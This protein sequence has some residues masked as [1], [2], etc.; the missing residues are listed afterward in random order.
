MD[1]Y[2]TKLATCSSDRS[3]KIFDVRGDQQALVADLKGFVSH[4]VCLSLCHCL[5]VCL[6]VTVSALVGLYRYIES[7]DEMH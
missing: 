5:S 1:Y 7:L 4:S 2:G 3:V 6:S